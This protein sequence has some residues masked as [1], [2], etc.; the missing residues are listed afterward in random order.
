MPPLQEAQVVVGLGQHSRQ[1]PRLQVRD[2]LAEL[3]ITE[4]IIQELVVVAQA[5]REQTPHQ[6]LEEMEVTVSPFPFRELHKRIRM[7]VVVAHE[8]FPEVERVERVEEVQE[9]E[10]VQVVTQHTTEVVEV[11]LETG[12]EQVLQVVMG[13]KE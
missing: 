3:A 8:V 5:V 1:V 9:T 4:Q 13:I 12:R 11:V 7:V 6:L 10:T 2:I